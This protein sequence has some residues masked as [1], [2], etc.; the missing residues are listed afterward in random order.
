MLTTRETSLDAIGAAITILIVAKGV[1]LFVELYVGH[2]DEAGHVLGTVFVGAVSEDDGA[3]VAGP[4][5][6][7][8]TA[9]HAPL[10]NSFPFSVL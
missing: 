6:P 4:A 2:G 3:R 9:M 10:R 5:V 8:G 7:A 1:V